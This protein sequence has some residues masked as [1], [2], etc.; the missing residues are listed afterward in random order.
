MD[1]PIVQFTS[2]TDASVSQAEQYISLADGDVERAVALFF[3]D[4]GLAPASPPPVPFASR[5]TVTSTT[6]R[7]YTEDSEGVV[8][9]DSDD[10]LDDDVNMQDAPTHLGPHTADDAEIARRMQEEMYGGAS[11]PNPLEDDIP[12]PMTRTRETLLGGPDE[13]DPSG[14]SDAD[15]TAMVQEQ[16]RQRERRRRGGG[17]YPII[18][19]FEMS[20][21]SGFGIFNQRDTQSA[22]WQNEAPS[23]PNPDTQAQQ[24]AEATDGQSERTSKSRNLAEMFRPPWEIITRVTSFDEAKE[25]GRDE[26]KWILVNVQDPSVFDSSVLNR[27]LWKDKEVQNIIK[28]NFVFVQFSKDDDRV[29]GGVAQEYMQYYFTA[30][31]RNDTNAYPHIAIVDPRTGEQLKVW[32]GAPVPEKQD[33]LMQVFEF[34]DRYSLNEDAKNP[35]AK[36]KSERRTERDVSRMTEEEMLEMAMRESLAPA[37]E[38]QEEDPDEL[39]KSVTLDKGKG[40]AESEAPNGEDDDSPATVFGTISSST[41]H[42]EPAADPATTTRI[43]FRYSGGRV[44]RRFAIND[45][46]RRLYE[47]LKAEPLEGKEGQEFDIMYMGKNLITQL[48]ETVEEAHLKNG[49][50]MVEFAG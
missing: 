20:N 5:P 39:T 8:H 37:L 19:H 4:P 26:Y 35:V 44:V 33:F 16:L 36:R 41:P 30:S 21:M 31:S 14:M 1:D 40:R 42:E 49:S 15:V 22:M 29:A 32:S 23:A 45:P 17:T 7:G 25:L 2:I 12:A 50:V 43:Q 10:D 38:R 24:L 46:V 18:N 34:L 28:E 47:W 9:I 6:R 48:D 27:D 13:L 3:E 11:G